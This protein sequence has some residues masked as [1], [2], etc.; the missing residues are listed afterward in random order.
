MHYLLYLFNNMV[1]FNFYVVLWWNSFWI[2]LEA[3]KMALNSRSPYIFRNMKIFWEDV[4]EGE[5]LNLLVN[6]SKRTLNSEIWI[7]WQIIFVNIFF[8]R[9]PINIG[10]SRMLEHIHNFIA[11]ESGVKI[12]LFHAF[13]TMLDLYGIWELR[14]KFNCWY[15]ILQYN[16]TTIIFF[17]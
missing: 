6:D 4:S 2:E 15:I 7:V 1:T 13:E 3:S 11:D 5:S 12:Q 14:Y 9:Y 8:N 10:I 16:F 17:I